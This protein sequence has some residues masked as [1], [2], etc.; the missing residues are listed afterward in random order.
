VTN[1]RPSGIGITRDHA[2]GATTDGADGW[3]VFV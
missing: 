3:I 2:G 1:V